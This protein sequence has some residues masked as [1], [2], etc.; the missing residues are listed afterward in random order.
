MVRYDRRAAHRGVRARLIGS[1]LCGV[2]AASAGAVIVI[3]ALHSFVFLIVATI[4]GGFALVA[5]TLAMSARKEEEVHQLA[6]KLSRASLE[7]PRRRP[8]ELHTDGSP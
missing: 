8:A 6:A 3:S 7:A 5:I 1:A 4:A 2:I